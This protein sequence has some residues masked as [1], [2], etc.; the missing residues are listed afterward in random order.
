VASSPVQSEIHGL[1]RSA[2]AVTAKVGAIRSPACL[3]FVYKKRSIIIVKFRLHF[4]ALPPFGILLN[5]EGLDLS[6]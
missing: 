6:S 4:T 2:D 1:V 3:F 5:G